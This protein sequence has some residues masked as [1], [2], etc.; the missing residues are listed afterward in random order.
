[1]WTDLTEVPEINTWFKLAAERGSVMLLL[2]GRN[3]RYKKFRGAWTEAE[4]VEWIEREMGSQSGW[5]G[6]H[7][8]WGQFSEVLR[9]ISP[10]GNPR[11]LLYSFTVTFLLLVSGLFF[12]KMPV[13]CA[14]ECPAS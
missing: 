5:I 10:D 6:A 3:D 4:M 13:S 11:F 9:S 2:D 7:R 8:F 14:M 12:A 1:M